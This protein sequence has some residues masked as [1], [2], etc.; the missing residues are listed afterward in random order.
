MQRPMKI[1]IRSTEDDRLG[2]SL[3]P[4]YIKPAFAGMDIDVEP[5]LIT[6]QSGIKYYK[7][8]PTEH[9]YSLL[10]NMQEHLSMRMATK[11]R[12]RKIGTVYIEEGYAVPS[13][14]MNRDFLFLLET[15]E[16]SS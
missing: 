4:W 11:F 6:S 15:K 14:T 1:K 16:E 13:G 5:N 3:A 2:T 7:L 12:E 8:L 9:N 10:L